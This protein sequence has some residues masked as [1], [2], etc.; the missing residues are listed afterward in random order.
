MFLQYSGSFFVARSETKELMLMIK[1]NI[2]ILLTVYTD[3]FRQ[4]ELK[5]KAIPQMYLLLTTFFFYFEKFPRA[6]R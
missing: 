5:H 4:N 1:S 6:I 3:L 2:R